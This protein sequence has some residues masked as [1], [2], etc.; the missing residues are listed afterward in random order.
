MPLD[1]GNLRRNR[2]RCRFRLV[3]PFRREY[4]LVPQRKSNAED[5]GPKYHLEQGPERNRKPRKRRERD[6][7]TEDNERA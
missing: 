5:A 7:E 4:A 2:L 6:E 1:C 3:L